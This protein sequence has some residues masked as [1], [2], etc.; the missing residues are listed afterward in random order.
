MQFVQLG[1]QPRIL[2]CVVAPKTRN[3]ALAPP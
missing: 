2:R 1:Q 3:R